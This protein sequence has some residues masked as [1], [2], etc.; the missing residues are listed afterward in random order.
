MKRGILLIAVLCVCFS[1]AMSQIDRMRTSSRFNGRF[2]AAMAKPQKLAYVQGFY[3]GW[4]SYTGSSQCAEVQSA[5]V[6]PYRTGLTYEEIM[7][8][9]ESF[10][11]EDA[12]KPIPIAS[13]IQ[14][15]VRKARGAT[16]QE[17]QNYVVEQRRLS[18]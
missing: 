3:D 2:W 1:T 18:S 17:L 8:E 14:Y 11:R 13:A 12:N 16:A 4:F 15:A 7:N 9:V 5:V 6:E 10:Y